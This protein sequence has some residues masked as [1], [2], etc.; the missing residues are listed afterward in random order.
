MYSEPPQRMEVSEELYTLAALCAREL[1]VAQKE[2]GAA[3][4]PA[5]VQLRWGKW[6]GC[7]QA[8]ESK[9]KQNGQKNKFV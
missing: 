4:T 5:G 2:Q 7:P 6:C 3:W 8:A 1:P 9:K